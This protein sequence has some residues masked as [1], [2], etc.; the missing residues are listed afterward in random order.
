MAADELRQ[1]FEAYA[2]QLME[3]QGRLS[4]NE[5]PELLPGYRETFFDENAEV[6]A[7]DLSNGA[8]G[9][10]FRPDAD[11]DDPIPMSEHV[12][13]RVNTMRRA[14]GYAGLE[15]LVAYSP[16]EPPSIV[17]QGYENA[18]AYME[19]PAL[20]STP[21]V[22][23]EGLFTT[24]KSM[25]HLRLAF[26]DDYMVHI[27]HSRPHVDGQ[28]APAPLT[29]SNYR[30]VSPRETFK[31]T[32]LHHVLSL[33]GELADAASLRVDREVPSF[34]VRYY[35]A[36]ERYLGAEV[37]MQLIHMWLKKGFAL[38]PIDYN[39]ED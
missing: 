33:G 21:L 35:V 5:N 22:S 16:D 24:F 13:N 7:F 34:A 14:I 3:L 9:F 17:V 12:I 31:H 39:A 4:E 36:C 15:Q 37:G 1:R 11:V 23:Y 18:L 6:G 32:L 2:E 28:P 38:P 27:T 10:I 25:Q 30:E 8:I 19:P 20:Q 29:V 26:F